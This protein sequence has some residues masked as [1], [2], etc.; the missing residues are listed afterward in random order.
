MKGQPKLSRFW[1][2]VWWSWPWSKVNISKF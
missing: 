1:Q 2:N